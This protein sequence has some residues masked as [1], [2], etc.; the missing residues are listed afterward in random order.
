MEKWTRRTIVLVAAIIL[1]NIF[2]VGCQEEKVTD[3]PEA[4]RMYKLLSMKYGRLQEQMDGQK[5]QCD[6]KIQEQKKLQAGQMQRQKSQ[7]DNCL[8]QKTAL[9]EISRDGID[10]YMQNVV[11]PLAEE[12]EKL[13]KQNEDLKARI[14]DLEKQ[15]KQLK[16]KIEGTKEQSGLVM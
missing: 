6:K 13:K 16:E 1:A 9:Q 14:E 4:E 12:S 8:K 10:S 11:G 3:E 7:L 5:Q 15:L 2:V